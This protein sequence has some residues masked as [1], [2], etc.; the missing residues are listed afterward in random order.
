MTPSHSTYNGAAECRAL[1]PRLHPAAPAALAR[2]TSTGTLCA[3]FGLAGTMA[4]APTGASATGLG[5]FAPGSVVVSQG[6]SIFGG[7][8]AGTGVELNGEVDVYP[9]NANGDVAPQASFT[10]GSY[11]PVTMIFDSWGDLWVANDLRATSSSSPRPSWPGGP[12][13]GRH[14][15]RRRGARQP[16]RDGLRPGGQ[17]LGGEQR[18]EQGYEY[19]KGQLARSGAPTPHT[20]ISDFPSTPVFGV[21]FDASGDLWV[22]TLNSLVEFSRAELATADPAP[23]VTISS[24]G[25]AELVFDP[26]GDLW[27]VN[28]GGPSCYGTPCTNEVVEFTKSELSTSGSPGP[29]V[30]IGST[31]PGAPGSLYGPYSLAFDPR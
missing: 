13:A 20:T 6:G 26:S 11:G 4:V 10:N 21:A 9:P 29:A 15:L 31:Q 8:N 28:G 2:S 3:L 16:L 14:H 24:S 23:T 19:T 25:G 17:P 18:F 5:P 1:S 30:T 22:S 27:A 7:T 12:R